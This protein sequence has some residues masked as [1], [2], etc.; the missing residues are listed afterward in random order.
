MG[1]Q[2]SCATTLPSADLA[3]LKELDSE[4]RV[5]SSPISPV[6]EEKE[7]QNQALSLS[8]PNESAH[9][10][11]ITN[12]SPRTSVIVNSAKQLTKSQRKNQ[13]RAARRKQKRALQN[14]RS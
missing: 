13:K 3:S 5:Q 12:N 6:K 9:F 7:T 11:D 2:N 14:Q 4:I 8:P 1:S 10:R